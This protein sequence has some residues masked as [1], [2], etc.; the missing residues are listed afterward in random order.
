MAAKRGKKSSRTQVIVAVLVLAA[1]VVAAW[2]LSDG[3]WDD[4]FDTAGLRSDV[5]AAQQP[6]A[7]HYL[8][9]GQA[10]STLIK[11][12]ETAVLIDG[13]EAGNAQAIIQYLRNQ[14]V[15]TLEYVI[16][17][18]PHADHIGGLAKIIAAFEVKNVIL[19]R[20]SEQN[21]P[22]TKTYEN[23]LL[24]VQAS[25]A[26]VI[27][28]KPGLS[29]SVGGATMEILGP[30]SDTA[31][32]NNQS[33]IARLCYGAVSFLFTGDAETEVEEELLASSQTLRANVLKAG[34]HGSSTSSSASFL[35]AVQ[36][37]L[38]IFSCG[39][40]NSYGH[41]HEEIRKR[42]D[43]INAKYLRTDYCGNIVV[44]TDGKSIMTYYDTME[45]AA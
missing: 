43:T 6:F 45:D 14:N 33:V 29:Y 35:Q 39:K 18:H 24:A 27:A 17:T 2:Y 41:P 34:H 42:M 9:V 15:S 11:A 22:T 38:V 37:E 16:A 40:D 8:D 30:G 28:A 21:T 1:I 25:G 10:D 20:M 32:I 19:P 13:G 26:K 5:A 44:G 4:L 36:P 12:G 3:A 31:D 7:V 23:L